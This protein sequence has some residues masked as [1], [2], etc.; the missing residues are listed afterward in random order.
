[1][2]NFRRALVALSVLF[3]LA[4]PLQGQTLDSTFTSYDWIP[5]SLVTAR[6][7]LL[8]ENGD[9]S[10]FVP[11]SVLLHEGE[12]LDALLLEIPGITID[13]RGN[14]RISGRLV[15]ELLVEGHRYFGTDVAS[16]LRNIPAN[17]IGSIRAYEKD[18]DVGL[19]SGVDQAD[20]E[21]VI[22]VT[23]KQRYKGRFNNSLKAAAGWK[24]KYDGK[25]NGTWIG[26]G[27][28]YS[29]VAGSDN[30]GAL[31]KSSG[32]AIRAGL[33]DNS[34]KRQSEAGITSSVSAK[35]MDINTS[36]IYKATSR[37]ARFSGRDDYFRTS[38]FHYT[39]NTGLNADRNRQVDAQSTV[40]W[41]DLGKVRMMLKP[42][43]S[44]SWNASADSLAGMSFREDSLTPYYSSLR[45]SLGGG[46]A[47]RAGSSLILSKG[48]SRSGRTIALN[49]DAWYNA[50]N[51]RVRARTDG[52]FSIRGRT[53]SSFWDRESLLKTRGADTW[54]QL[55]YNEPFSKRHSLQVSYKQ[56][57]QG[58][59]FDRDN[60]LFD[61]EVPEKD[62][63]QCTDGRYD[64]LSG[65]LSVAWRLKLERMN[66]TAG[67]SVIPVY[68]TFRFRQEGNP[69]DTASLRLNI[70]PRVIWNWNI[71]EHNALKFVYKGYSKSPSVRQMLPI[72]ANTNPV[73]VQ[74][75][76][77]GLRPSFTQEMTLTW[78]VSDAAGAK[79]LT[80]G[81]NFK[82]VKD[83][84]ST[85]AETDGVSRWR[86]VTP[87]NV[88]GNLSAGLD[89]A[90]YVSLGNIL[91]TSHSVVECLR[92]HIY[93][94][95][96]VD[97]VSQLGTAY[98][99]F[100]KQTF[101]VTYRI[102][103]FEVNAQVEGERSDYRL[104]LRPDMDMRPWKLSVGT[105]A[106][107]QPGAG[108][109]LSADVNERRDGGYSFGFLNRNYLIMNAKISKCI[110]KEKLII[111]LDARDIFRSRQNTVLTMGMDRRGYKLYAGDASY[112]LGRLMVIL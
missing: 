17:L 107:W 91:F 3:C 14:V 12:T 36:V 99:G 39:E 109:T 40:E 26:T 97:R 69:T 67:L 70:C 19:I 101:L 42:R 96:D 64:Y 41:K 105:A 74:N 59:R 112:I 79:G 57:W 92:N 65:D 5:P 83:G 95:N 98:S 90:F 93:V 9:T 89:A 53:F 38:G 45:H 76:N 15:R 68:S 61:K 52:L 87:V 78:K 72:A 77:P 28:L 35:G 50:D 71:S 27:G 63:S 21:I 31:Q 102:A 75:P 81:G 94:F 46:T 86:T 56:T 8:K 104:D 25:Y 10:L 47:L 110:W 34:G 33:G 20:K 66:L 4:F 24:D 108:W 2:S 29:F 103:R 111:Q 1:M 37:E 88:D 49:V 13:A 62:E 100:M 48:L 51:E 60:T 84:F 54:A 82:Y 23:V 73:Y 106:T 80:L 6:T 44:Y 58:T 43:V 85:L 22:D 30:L 55:I 18:S 7:G 32:T 16:G 11:S